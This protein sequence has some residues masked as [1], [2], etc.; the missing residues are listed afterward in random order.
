M[1]KLLLFAI[2]ALSLGSIKAGG[3]R[4]EET[5]SSTPWQLIERDTPTYNGD[6]ALTYR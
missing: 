4:L 5:G 1:K 3:W 6:W 2:L